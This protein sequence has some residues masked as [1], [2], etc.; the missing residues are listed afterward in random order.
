MSALL[1]LMTVM[2]VLPVQ[3]LLVHLHAHV[4]LDLLERAQL[5][6]VQV[7]FLMPCLF[8]SITHDH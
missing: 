2:I 7:R 1:A 3:T 6:I 8:I 5:E 4:L